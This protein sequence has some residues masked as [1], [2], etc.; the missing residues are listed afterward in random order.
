MK[1]NVITTDRLIAFF[2]ELRKSDHY[3]FA[4]LK[5]SD[6]EDF[7]L[8]GWPDAD[9]KLHPKVKD[10]V[11][12]AQFL[13][14]ADELGDDDIFTAYLDIRSKYEREYVDPDN[15][16]L[17]ALDETEDFETREF[18]NLF[19]AYMS[20]LCEKRAREGKLMQ[21]THE[22]IV[23]CDLTPDDI[24]VLT[25][26]I[27]QFNNRALEMLQREYDALKVLPFIRK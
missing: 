17:I 1:E 23:R 26:M 3:I 7:Y 25:P 8:R 24:A 5:D 4:M 2:D 19:T 27:D 11:T 9:G 15:I 6:L 22:M 12:F 10:D 20:Y 21:I 13:A 18:R 14:V 16:N